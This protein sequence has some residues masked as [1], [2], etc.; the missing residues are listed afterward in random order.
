MFYEYFIPRIE[1]YEY[2]DNVDVSCKEENGRLPHLAS[3]RNRNQFRVLLLS[4]RLAMEIDYEAALLMSSLNYLNQIIMLRHG[5]IHR[6]QHLFHYI[7]IHRRNIK[8]TLNT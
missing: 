2:Q 1:L 3:N 8:T 5:E 6:H 4:I 7:S